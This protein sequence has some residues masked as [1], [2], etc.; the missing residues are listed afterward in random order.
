VYLRFF[1]AAPDGSGK[2]F[3]NVLVRRAVNEAINIPSIIKNLL[4]G[5]AQPAATLMT[6]AFKYYDSSVK[7]YPYNVV[8]AKALMARAGYKKGFS[9]PFQV[10]SDGPSPNTVQ[11]V[12]AVAADLAKI[13]IH[14]NIQTY[15]SST[16]LEMQTKRKVS[17]FGLW[18]WGAA[19]L[20]PDDKFWGVFNPASSAT[21]LTTSKVAKLTNLGQ[22]TFNDT[23]RKKVYVQLQQLIHNDALIA[24]LFVMDA[25]YGATK[26]LDFHPRADGRI[27]FWS[28]PAK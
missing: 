20:D 2:P 21:F 4:A 3:K 26:A 28:Y 6:P 1:P 11:L 16:L 14:A 9:V 13:G 7:P 15:T 5:Q 12:Q 17:G 18:S 19:L 8:N 25:T 22:S 27:F 24:P 23:G 10:W